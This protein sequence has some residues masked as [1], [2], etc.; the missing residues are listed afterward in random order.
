MQG[1]LV[2]SLILMW[3]STSLQQGNQLGCDLED[4][5]RVFRYEKHSESEHDTDQH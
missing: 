3:A 5:C 4:T 1:L 2:I